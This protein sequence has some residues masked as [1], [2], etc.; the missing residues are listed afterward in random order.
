[1]NT[2][3]EGLATRV[4]FELPLAILRENLADFVLVSEEEI[5]RAMLLMMEATHNLVEA[6]GAAPLAAAL[7]I[8][9]RLR[10]RKVVLDLS[11]GNITLSALRELLAA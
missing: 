11:G 10:G 9:E 6:A 1:M 7:R 3:A 2:F 5:R 8:R 4:G